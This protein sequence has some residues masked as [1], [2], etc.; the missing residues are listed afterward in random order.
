MRLN[1]SSIKL[2]VDVYGPD[3]TGVFAVKTALVRFELLRKFISKTF[4]KIKH[5]VVCGWFARNCTKRPCVGLRAIRM[6][7][8]IRYPLAVDT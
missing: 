4:D 3:V 7:D 2:S 5:C 1:R 6:N 8:I